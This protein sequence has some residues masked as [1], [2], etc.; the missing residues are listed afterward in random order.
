M[1]G[2]TIFDGYRDALGAAAQRIHRDRR[3]ITL[4]TAEKIL[5][6]EFASRGVALE[7]AA[8]AHYART[9]HRGPSWPILHP[10][11]A[12]SEGYRFEWPWSRSENDDAGEDPWH[13]P[14]PVDEA[15]NREA[16]RLAGTGVG[17]LSVELEPA[18]CK[19]VSDNE[20]FCV[21]EMRSSES[22]PA[23][24]AEIAIAYTVGSQPRVIDSELRR[25]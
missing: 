22:H 17:A 12:R 24:R 18:M 5:Y 3:R 11:Q 9:F 20:F 13:T 21:A 19:R 25:R 1:E 6:E 15:A 7:R 2:K 10:R 8:A 4:D 14:A 16:W 23:H